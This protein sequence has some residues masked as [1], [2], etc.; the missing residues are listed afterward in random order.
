MRFLEK[1][2]MRE[3][4][5]RFNEVLGEGGYERDYPTLD[6]PALSHPRSHTLP[7]E[8]PPRSHLPATNPRQRVFCM[9]VQ[10]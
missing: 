10:K 7:P 6:D 5:H 8:V 9:V 4:C 3:H 1:E 2:A